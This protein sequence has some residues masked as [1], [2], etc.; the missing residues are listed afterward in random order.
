VSAG[1]AVDAID[2][3]N[4]L[5]GDHQAKSRF[6]TTAFTESSEH[7]GVSHILGEL[8]LWQWPC[9]LL[10]AG[11]L[12][13]GICRRLATLPTKIKARPSLVRWLFGKV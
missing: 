13:V 1:A 12:V 10:I 2:G 11:V 9:I 8:Q 6:D 3:P 5:A 4:G 7:A